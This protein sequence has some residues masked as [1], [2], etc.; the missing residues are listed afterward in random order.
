MPVKPAPKH[1]FFLVRRVPAELH[2]SVRIAAHK[3]FGSMN[4]WILR[5][6]ER[7]AKEALKPQN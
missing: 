1:K 2:E 6:L 4:T 3:E 7:A 5:T